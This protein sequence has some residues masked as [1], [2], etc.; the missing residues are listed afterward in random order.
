VADRA[1]VLAARGTVAYEGPASG[2]SAGDAR[3]AFGGAP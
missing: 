1:L 2:I 3:S